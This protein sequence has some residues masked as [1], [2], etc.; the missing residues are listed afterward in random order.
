[1]TTQTHAT[2]LEE[3]D[4]GW[5]A[6]MENTPLARLIFGLTGLTRLGEHPTT[7]ERLAQ[8]VDRPVVETAV[9][10]RGATT[11]RIEGNLIHWDE[12][13]PGERTRRTLFIGDRAIPMKFGCAPDLFA[14]AAVLDV[15][16]RVEDTDAVTGSPIRVD[17]VPNGYERVDPPET[18]TVLQSLSRIRD[19]QG[20]DFADTDASICANQPFFASIKA[21]EAALAASP[22][23][24]AF[25]V[26]EMFERP[27]FAYYRDNLRPLIHPATEA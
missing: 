13:F 2:D 16:F 8:V 3:F 21:A 25:T 4:Q 12:P 9:L 10:V 19:A 18:V 22:G 7:L 26:K 17:F 6:A 5:L 11:A 15:P 23:S 27:W 1:M 24:R 14:F 20:G